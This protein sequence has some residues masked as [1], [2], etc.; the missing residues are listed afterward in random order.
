MTSANVNGDG[1]DGAAVGEPPAQLTRLTAQAV[2]QPRF[3]A[4]R[5]AQSSAALLIRHVP[6]MDPAG[7]GSANRALTNRTLT[8]P[9][10]REPRRAGQ[11]TATQRTNPR[12]R[13]APRKERKM[14][15]PGGGV[16]IGRPAS[17]A[18]ELG[19][20]L[21][22]S[23]TANGP[24]STYPRPRLS[25]CGSP[26]SPTASALTAPPTRHRPAR[27][28]VE[29]SATPPPCQTTQTPA[30]YCDPH[31][32][33]RC[34]G[35]RVRWLARG[36]IRLHVGLVSSRSV[37]SLTPAGP[38]V[39]NRFWLHRPGELRKTVWRTPADKSA[40]ELCKCK[41]EELI[42]AQRRQ[43]GLAGP[44]VTAT[45][46]RTRTDGQARRERGLSALSARQC[47]SRVRLCSQH[48]ITPPSANQRP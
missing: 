25:S 24:V 7:P 12:P 6:S 4:A 2:R 13:P 28:S 34:G 22:P 33:Q 11:R 47:A 15:G 29:T 20:V 42:A 5:D 38:V 17:S 3:G 37:S 18:V 41:A 36:G 40:P 32:H 39:R 30:A 14:H 44:A 1:C 31:P 35:R 10:L 43:L 16:Y 19:A 26:R 9:T 45:G 46:R 8:N 21:V 48:R 27:A 23:P